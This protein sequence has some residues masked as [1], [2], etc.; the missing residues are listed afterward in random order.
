MDKLAYF[1]ALGNNWGVQLQ[2]EAENDFVEKTASAGGEI[3]ADAVEALDQL[4]DSFDFQAVRNS[5]CYDEGAYDVLA[6]IASAFESE[7]TDAAE[8]YEE[9]KTAMAAIEENLPVAHDAEEQEAIVAELI[10]GASEG[11]AAA[12][13]LDEITEDVVD[14]AARLVVGYLSE[15]DEA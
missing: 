12:Q 15:D 7:E 10:K 5:V 9:I 14:T 6:K 13:G 11:L 2:L 4:Q 1:R 3:D 8:L